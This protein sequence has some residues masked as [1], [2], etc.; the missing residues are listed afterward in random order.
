MV[1]KLEEELMWD[2]G[3]DIMP[4]YLGGDMVLLMGLS[5]TRAEDLCREED[6]SGLSMFHTLEKWSLT[7][8]SSFRMVWVLC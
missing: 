8:K 1:N 6:E 2:R 7:M 4:K 3:E 5:D